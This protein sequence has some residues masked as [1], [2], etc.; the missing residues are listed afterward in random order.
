LRL[1]FSYMYAQPGKKL[2]FMG[3]EFGQR[4]E[5]NHDGSLDWEALHLP[6]HR[7]VR[8][9]LQDLNRLLREEP[10]LYEVDF[11]PSGFSWIDA[12]DSEQSVVTLLRRGKSKDS[13]IVAAFNFTPVPRY[14]YRIG[15]PSGGFWRELLNSDAR[16]YGGSGQGNMGGLQSAPLGWHGHPHSLMATLPPLGAVFFKR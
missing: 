6:L 8:R 12:N 13:V 5:W 9:W 1:L 3:G 2:L 14:N 7:G 16:D 4:G 15:V 11:D 10:A